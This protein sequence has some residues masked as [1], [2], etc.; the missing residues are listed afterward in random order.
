MTLPLMPK[1]TATWLVD[2]TALTFEQIAKFC[3]MHVIEVRAIADG[4]VASNI[5]G[6]DP[7]LNGQI[8]RKNLEECEKDHSKD[9][10]LLQNEYVGKPQKKARKYTPMAKRE[11]R[12]DA[13][14]WLVKHYP[15]MEDIK[16]VRLVG[17]TR[18]TVAAI[19]NKTHK[20]MAVIKPRSPVS[21]GL[22]TEEELSKAAEGLKRV[23]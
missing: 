15:D 20:S 1:A 10:I 18:A 6:F 11:D 16:I 19:K 17:T 23:I 21:V 22:C 9:L 14:A 5:V 12:P 3:N 2:N 8:D 7:V 13:I 4:D